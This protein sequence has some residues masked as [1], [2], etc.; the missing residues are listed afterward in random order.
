MAIT[1]ITM[2]SSIRVNPAIIH[3]AE[4][5][6]SAHGAAPRE[7]TA[8]LPCYSSPGASLRTSTSAWSLSLLA[9]VSDL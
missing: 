6:V 4:Y 7:I 2:R 3:C 9:R 1:A 5:P 8:N